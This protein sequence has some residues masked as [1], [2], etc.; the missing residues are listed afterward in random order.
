MEQI[1]F[2][3]SRISF[4][5]TNDS[6]DSRWRKGTIFY[7]TLSLQPA[8]QHSHIYFGS[9]LTRWLSHIF[10]RTACIYQAATQWDLPPCRITIWLIDDVI[11]IFVYLLNDLIQGFCNSYLTLETGGIELASFIILALQ[12]SRLTKC[13]GH[14]KLFFIYPKLLFFPKLFFCHQLL[15]KLIWLVFDVF[16]K[17]NSLAPC[18]KKGKI[19]SPNTEGSQEIWNFLRP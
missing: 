5:D 6:Q 15:L 8:H 9:L 13:G 7:S 17:E 14:P 11:L 10:N 1:A 3:L 19:R 12:A 16:M 4:T 18:P 2:F